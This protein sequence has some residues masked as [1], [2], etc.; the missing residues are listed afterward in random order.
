MAAAS[1]SRSTRWSWSRLT[2]ST[3]RIPRWA[4][5]RSPGSKAFT[6]SE[7]ARSMSSAPTSRSSDAPTGSSTV[8]AARDTP[9]PASC[10]PSGHAGSGAP[11]SH[12]KRHPATTATSGMRAAS[13]RTA[14]DFAVP[15]SPRTRTPPTAGL[16]AL[17][18]SPSRRSSCPTRA[19]KGYGVLTEPPL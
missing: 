7:R 12:E 6:P 2:S 9:V 15:F 11:G 14:V 4:S 10:G 19:V 8:R 3:Y 18:S 5:A 13:A 16:T 17:S 1:S